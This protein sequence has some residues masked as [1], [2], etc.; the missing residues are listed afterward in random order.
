MYIDES[1]NTGFGATAGDWFVLSAVVSRASFDLAAMGVVDA[2]LSKLW[3]AGRN[4]PHIHT[5]N[6]SHDRKVAWMTLIAGCRCRLVSVIMHK[7][8]L[9]RSIFGKA[10]LLYS[11]TTK[12]LLERVT[13]LCD[14]HH[15]GTGDGTADIYF[16]QRHNRLLPE[17][18]QYIRRLRRVSQNIKWSVVREP[19]IYVRPTP[20]MKGLQVADAVAHAFYRSVQPNEFG[21]VEPRY[22]GILRPIVH[23]GARNAHLG[24]GVK[25]YPDSAAPLAAGLL[26]LG[27]NS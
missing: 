10:N 14:S 6:L 25:L 16:S 4:P 2:A 24:C 1:G 27:W 7:R 11:Y 9:D 5:T 17:I 22:A 12:M 13:M 20:S 21:N 3:P 18:V 15:D 8:S 23:R 19:Q 26:S